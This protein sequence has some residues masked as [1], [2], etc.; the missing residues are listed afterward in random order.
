MAPLVGL[1]REGTLARTAPDRAWSRVTMPLPTPAP[2]RPVVGLPLTDREREA[3]PKP[4]PDDLRV[5]AAVVQGRGIKGAAASLGRRP[6]TVAHR[7]ER[8]RRRMGVGT[9]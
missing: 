2:S 6:S 7:M 5:I 1:L 4:T 8:I 3:A 9:T